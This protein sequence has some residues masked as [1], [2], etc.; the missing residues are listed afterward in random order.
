[1]R[2]APCG[3]MRKLPLGGLAAL[4][5]ACGTAP[6]GFVGDGAGLDPDG[7][8]GT[9]K[10]RVASV[11]GG[12]E[13]GLDAPWRL[14]PIGVDYV[15]QTGTY[16]PIPIVVSLNDASM[17]TDPETKKP[18]GTFCGVRIHEAW[19]DGAT[20]YDP[21]D[22]NAHDPDVQPWQLD[23]Y[24][25]P[26]DAALREIER[27]DK[28]S[29]SSDIA[30]NHR[31]CRHWR[32]DNCVN[33]LDASRS[34]EWHAT[35]AYVPQ[36]LLGAGTHA[37]HF[38]PIR[39]GDDVKLT[40]TAEFAKIGTSCAATGTMQRISEPVTIHLGE[41]ELPRFDNG[42]VYGDLHYHSQGTDNDG[43]NGYAYRPTL[44][45]MRAMGLDFAFATDHA[46][47]SAQ[48]T[49]LDPLFIDKMP[50][51]PYTPQFLEEMAQDLLNNLL[52]SATVLQ[53]IDAARDMNPSRFAY[54]RKWLNN[55][56]NDLRPGAN[57]EAMRSFTGGTRAPRLFLGGE[58]D[59]IPEISEAEKQ[60]G[61][62]SYGNKKSYRWGASCYE[63]PPEFLAVGR[64]TTLDACPTGRNDLLENVSEGGRYMVKDI[65]GLLQRMNARQHVVYLPKDGTRDDAFVSSHSGLYGG[66]HERLKDILRPEYTNTMT[67]KGYGFLA[68]PMSG[69]SGDGFGRLGPDIIPYSDV[70]LKT[71]FDSPTIL[72]LQLWN[73]DT[74]M[75]RGAWQG[76][77]PP[78]YWDLHNGAAAWDKMLQWGLRPSQTGSLSWIP[79][80]MPRRVYMAGGSDAHGD[81]NYRREG[82]TSGTEYLTDSALG[83][84]RNLVNVGLTRPE[85]VLSADGS[86]VGVFTQEQI[87]SALAAG[88]FSVTDGPAVRIAIDSNNNGVIDA[89]D[90]PMGSVGY[91]GTGTVPVIIEWLS[92]SEFQP[93]ASLDVY[94]G[95][96]S[97]VTDKTVVYAPANH[98]A[99]P[100]DGTGVLDPYSYMSGGTAYRQ[101]KDGYMAD[102]TGLLHIVPTP[103][104]YVGSQYHGRRTILIRASDYTVGTATDNATYG[105][106]VCKGNFYCRKPGFA[107][108][109]E[110]TCT[111]PVTH[112][113]EYQSAQTPNRMYVRAFARTGTPPIC[114]GTSATALSW[115]ARGKCS[116]RLAYTNPVWMV[117]RP[118]LWGG[119]VGPIGP[120]MVLQP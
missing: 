40:I 42:W 118:P 43:E 49:D 21:L 11:M 75:S 19:N 103:A 117:P 83:K 39:S 53:S 81:W 76:A 26:T 115:Q 84:P 66:A 15:Y 108:L 77:A 7:E 65:Q 105:P 82:A 24:I 69:A 63:L 91:L 4:L 38:S 17:Q 54:L 13:F 94:V 61:M 86:S 45:A 41:G 106:E 10:Q 90:V 72:G 51:V 71:A 88:A 70:Q 6:D 25:K 80:G 18:Y 59:V 23:T 110:Y 37:Q 46:S 67:G 14:E 96:A 57:A 112:S 79:S 55:P 109:C 35:V 64:Y 87:T 113:Y 47:D 29:N 36:Q 119:V 74:R 28:W 3:R 32:G 99:R 114:A 111:Q 34:A 104:D 27:S 8:T 92:T 68:H 22:P 52:K 2:V 107:E 5:I 31:L 30:P 102:R 33:E 101:L 89:G 9:V 100:A 50:D 1:M 73:E 116:E 44:Q 20:H 62:L 60:S 95:A 48:V 120:I 56:A 97:T 98:G 12:A 85:S 78:A 16:A 58:V 93:V